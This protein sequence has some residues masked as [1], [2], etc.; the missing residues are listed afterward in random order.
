[1]PNNNMPNNNMPNNNMPNNNM[2]NNNM[3]NNNKSNNLLGNDSADRILIHNT[4]MINGQTPIDTTPK[5]DMQKY[6]E[7]LKVSWKFLDLSILK[8]E[9]L[10]DICR[11]LNIN[12]TGMETRDVYINKITMYRDLFR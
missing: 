9:G 11:E 1:M 7:Y 3:P 2:P 12:L 4:F 6:H 5:D 10:R 8:V